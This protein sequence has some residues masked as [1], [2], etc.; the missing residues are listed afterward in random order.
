PT[1]SKLAS[2]A[3]MPL[4]DGPWTVP[5]VRG[6]AAPPRVLPPLSVLGSACSGR[7]RVVS[8]LSLLATLMLRRGSETPLRS[9][10]VTVGRS[11]LPPPP[12]GGDCAGPVRPWTGRTDV[13]SMKIT[14]VLPVQG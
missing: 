5:N 1:P 4:V 10:W 11:V 6:A 8:F 2:K 12:C 14:P 3:G 7:T 13:K 9:D